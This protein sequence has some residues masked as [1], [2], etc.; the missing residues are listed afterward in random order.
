VIWL[1][2][3]NRTTVSEEEQF[4]DEVLFTNTIDL[5]DRA[6]LFTG[7]VRSLRQSAIAMGGVVSTVPDLH[8]D[9]VATV[10]WDKVGRL[11]FANIIAAATTSGSF[12]CRGWCGL[13]L[14]QHQHKRRLRISCEC[15]AVESDPI[16][17][18][19][20]LVAAPLP[21][22]D[23]EDF[24]ANSVVK[25]SVRIW[26]TSTG[27]C[28]R[29]VRTPLTDTLAAIKKH[30]PT[31]YSFGVALSCVPTMSLT[32]IRPASSCTRQHPRCVGKSF[33]ALLRT[34]KSHSN[35]VTSVALSSNGKLLLRAPSHSTR[36]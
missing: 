19:F 14:V 28:L 8:A 16:T 26:D 36:L 7:D 29:C 18:T 20:C 21:A 10:S 6:L 24:P 13:V 5:K 23:V 9:A 34:I 17:R 3:P 11:T 32:L 25:Q 15:Y 4:L 35:R 27:D 30:G 22:A 12:A 1:A 2:R 31:I 33:A